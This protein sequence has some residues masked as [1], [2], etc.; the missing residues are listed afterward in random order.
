[1][2]GDLPAQAHAERILRN[3]NSITRACAEHGPLIYV[4]HPNRIEHMTL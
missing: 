4:V 2:R 3:L 1:M